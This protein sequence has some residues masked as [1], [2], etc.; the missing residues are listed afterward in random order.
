MEKQ[1]ELIRKTIN[2][3][4]EKGFIY[5]PIEKTSDVELIKEWGYGQ[6]DSEQVAHI[7]RNYIAEP[8]SFFS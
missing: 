8:N 5:Y 2:K 7:E 4:V 3:M 6:N 1:A